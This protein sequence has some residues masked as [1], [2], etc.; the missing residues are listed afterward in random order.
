MPI[1]K[2]LSYGLRYALRDNAWARRRTQTLLEHDR[3][4]E[5][6]LQELRDAYL[7]RTLRAASRGLRRYAH[8]APP[9]SP[10]EALA[11][12]Q[13]NY[14]ILSR[15]DLMKHRQLYYPHGGR[16]LPWS[17]KGKTSG[18]TGTPLEVFRSMDSLRWENAFKR[19]HWAWAGFEDGMKRATL[20]GDNVV[21]VARCK[22]PFW[23]FNRFNNQLL[24]S[25]RHL[26]TLYMGQIAQ[27][28]VEF[29]PHL[30]EAYP[31]T[32]FAL[33]SY[34]RRENARLTIPFVFTGSEILYDYQRELIEER[35][36][37]VMDFYGMA[38]RVA[39]ASECEAGNLHVNT[40]YSFVEIVDDDG[41]ETAGC[42]FV[43]GTTFHNLVMP[44]IRY[45][46]S[47]RTTWKPGQCSCGRSYPMIEPIAGKFEDVIFGGEGEPISPSLVTF[48]FKGVSNI[49]SSQVAQVSA[50]VWE[51]RIVPLADYSDADGRQVIQNIHSM[52]DEKIQVR[53]K[54][55]LDI[56]RT[57]A[58][59]YR[60]VINES[61]VR[62]QGSP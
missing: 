41:Q 37:R 49:E 8:V 46:L 55:V 35:I 28:L 62:G 22:P 52:V 2:N 20:R 31:S 60:W 61:N 34:L 43:V 33:A 27:A 12:L 11:C 36:G 30:L 6:R 7:H 19:R 14:P 10:A 38:E 18:T 44:L 51:V 32:A 5:N 1:L 57:A 58:G 45:R 17:V 29:G 4:P 23:L 16:S 59:K 50:G 13:S 25:S 48:A 9:A 26:K 53:T 3:W 39:F 54:I 15:A 21:P 40:D 47:D 42:G 24:L 56:P